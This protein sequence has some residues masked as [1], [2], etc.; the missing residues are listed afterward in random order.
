MPR[1]QPR[2]SIEIRSQWEQER[3]ESLR[4]LTESPPEQKAEL[5][6][7]WTPPPTHSFLPEPEELRRHK[8][9]RTE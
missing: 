3:L 9:R 6:A 1:K 8:D 7:N 5:L 2:N 4:F